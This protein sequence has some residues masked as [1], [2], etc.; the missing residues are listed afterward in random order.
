MELHRAALSGQEV[1][2]DRGAEARRRAPPAAGRYRRS[3]AC[4]PARRDRAG[5]SVRRRARSAAIRR[6]DKRRGNGVLGAVLLIEEGGLQL[7]R[8]AGRGDLLR[9]CRGIERGD[10][11]QIAVRHRPIAYPEGRRLPKRR[12]HGSAEDRDHARRVFGSAGGG[13]EERHRP[14]GRMGRRVDEIGRDRL[15]G[16]RLEE[17]GKRLRPHA[18]R[19]AAGGQ[20]AGRRPVSR[21]CRRPARRSSRPRPATRHRCRWPSDSNALAEPVLASTLPA[22]RLMRVLEWCRD[23]RAGAGHSAAGHQHHLAPVHAVLVRP[24]CFG[25]GR[26]DPIP[27]FRPPARFA[28]GERHP[29]YTIWLRA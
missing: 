13:E 2:E 19:R 6:P 17:G 12:R 14:V 3:A 10:E 8:P 21:W 22:T 27:T 23:Q 25:L 24:A 5:R 7:G 28:A 15:A 16:R 18:L 1:V 20:R 26:H 11:R 9:A 29:G 4:R